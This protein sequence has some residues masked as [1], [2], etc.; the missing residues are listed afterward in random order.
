MDHQ[1]SQLGV[2]TGPK[3]KVFELIMDMYPD[4]AERRRRGKCDEFLTWYQ[5]KCLS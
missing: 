4:L 5:N 1:Q 3:E 2:E